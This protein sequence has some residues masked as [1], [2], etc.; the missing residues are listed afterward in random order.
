M[1]ALTS[2]SSSGSELSASSSLSWK[3]MRGSV[4]VGT[5]ASVGI[6]GRALGAGT[7][8]VVVLF[9]VVAFGTRVTGSGA[10]GTDET[11][12]REEGGEGGEEAEAAIVGTS[13]G[14]ASV[15]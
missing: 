12:E 14:W 5:A 1:F 7:V 10:E 15:D 3:L 4:A 8:V 13:M 11:E 2:D 9:V 6:R